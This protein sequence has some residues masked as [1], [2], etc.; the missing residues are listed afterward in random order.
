M[1]SDTCI[2][3]HLAFGRNQSSLDAAATLQRLCR[4]WT[5]VRSWEGTGNKASHSSPLP[6]PGRGHTPPSSHNGCRGLKCPVRNHLIVP[7]S[8]MTQFQDPSAV[9]KFIEDTAIRYF[10]PGQVSCHTRLGQL[11]FSVLSHV[12]GRRLQ[13]CHFYCIGEDA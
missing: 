1:S 2:C 8:L 5:G 11:Q 6:L 10:F 9:I 4:A 3:L 7:W 13:N 12:E